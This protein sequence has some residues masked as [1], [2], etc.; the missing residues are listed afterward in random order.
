LIGIGGT[1]L[2]AIARVL[3][4]SG[5]TVSG[6]DRQMSPLA[7]ALQEAGV[8]VFIGHRAENIRGAGLVVRSSAIPESNVEVQ[9]A[10]EAGLLVLKRA[11]FL[12]SLLEGRLGI[13]V[14]GTHGKTTTTAMLAWILTSLG[15]DPSF[16]IGGV[17]MNLGTNAHS[18]GG[19]VFLIEADEYDRM[20]L[21]LSPQVAVVTNIE[22]DH[23][24]CY[25]TP[26]SFYGAFREFAGRVVPGGVL[27]GCGEDAGTRRLLIDA[28]AAGIR[29]RS[30]GIRA[31]AA[32]EN[33]PASFDYTA[34]I[35]ALNE[36][37]GYRF[38]F[39]PFVGPEEKNGTTRLPEG[40]K[41]AVSL[42]APGRHNVL[43][44]AAA[45]A[46]I[47]WLGLP[48]DEAAEALGNFSGTGRRFQVVGEAQGV[49][50][51]D[52]YAHH[53]TEVQATLGAARKRYPGR[54]I[55]AIWQPHTYSR[56]LSLLEGFAEA[57]GE[58]DRVVVTGVY[59]A[60]E[61]APQG[62]TPGQ[63]G[64]Q[65]SA[66][67]RHPA[68]HFS[69]ELDEAAAY[70]L[71]EIRVGDVVM[72]LSAGDADRISRSVIEVLETLKLEDRRATR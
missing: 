66:A 48:L 40:E 49:T 56:T 7:Q 23:P 17:S 27:I 1:G 72:V 39:L 38:E 33:R 29:A 69:Q 35:I 64:A 11:D 46:V 37:G 54:R 22:H 34:Q 63:V 45:L 70:L 58:V 47:H 31:G 15:Q 12:G 25:P 3:L 13:G 53:P 62:S 57:F 61:S 14:A 50:V 6:S 32:V 42:Q 4:E 9:A 44:A 65:V 18:G 68:V 8:R 16:I 19:P 20:F 52:D 36:A 10:L 51:I 59:A 55:W 41:V 21:G 26:E 24:D 71:Q 43:N 5:Y 67:I 60:R 30:Y 2:S 28:A